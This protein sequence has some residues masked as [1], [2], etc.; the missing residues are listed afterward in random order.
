MYDKNDLTNLTDK[1]WQ[2]S[3]FFSKQSKR[4]R[5][6]SQKEILRAIIYINKTGCQW[7]MLPCEFPQWQLVYYYF[8]RW[9]REGVFDEILEDIRNTVRKS[10]GKQTSPSAGV[11]DSQSVKSGSFGGE[12]RGVDGNKKIN[13]RKRHIV[14]DTNGLLLSVVVHAANEYDGKKA[15]DVIKT[16]KHRFE[17][18]KTIY[19]DGGYRGDELAQKLKKELHYDLE[20]TLRN[21]RATEF[22]PLPK[23][24]VIERSFAWL[25]GFRRLAKD[26]EKLI[27]TCETMIII[28]FICLM[29][30]NQIFK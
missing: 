2:N 20:I 11:I 21:D 26:Y 12:N 5:K 29:L 25:N 3:D 24:W 30:N 16:L 9:K 22:K 6:H 15:F 23:R 8:Q 19:A 17:R 28:A 7:R 10:L 27:E 14:T 4:R 13:G 18:M 1:L